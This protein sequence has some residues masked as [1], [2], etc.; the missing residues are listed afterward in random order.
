MEMWRTHSWWK[1]KTRAFVQA[2]KAV[3]TRVDPF[4]CVTSA[5]VF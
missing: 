5:A 1:H 2:I 4:L 3:L